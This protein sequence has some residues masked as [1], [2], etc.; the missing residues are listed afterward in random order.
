MLTPDLFR[1]AEAVNDG[2]SDQRISLFEFALL[3]FGFFR[4]V[5]GGDVRIRHGDARIFHINV[6]GFLFGLSSRSSTLRWLFDGLE[7]GNLD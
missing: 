4:N 1:K 7:E 5:E 6:L 3:H 2:R